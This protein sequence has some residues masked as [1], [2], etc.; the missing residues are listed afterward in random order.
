ML[1]LYVW[2]QPSSFSYACD[3]TLHASTI[4]VTSPSKLHLYVWRHPQS[5]N[6]TCDVTLQPPTR[7]RT[8]PSRLQLYVWRQQILFTYVRDRPV[9][10][11]SPP[12]RC[13]PWLPSAYESRRASPRRRRGRGLGPPRRSCTTTR[14][15]PLTRPWCSATC[16]SP[17]TGRIVW[18][19]RLSPSSLHLYAT[20]IVRLL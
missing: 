15:R 16:A 13:A 19:P 18:R 12:W 1:Q 5:Y 14:S 4:S 17:Q 3:V 2:L 10:F 6:Y 7:Q 9:R 20:Q 11:P 8:S